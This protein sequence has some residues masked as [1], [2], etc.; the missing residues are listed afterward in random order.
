MPNLLLVGDSE[1]N[2]NLYYKT[3]FLA[4][5][6][7]VYLEKEG[8]GLLV[9]SPM[10]AGR[11]EKEAD[12][13]DVRTFDDFGYA[14]LVREL[15][16]RSAAFT[17]MLTRI[18]GNGAEPLTVEDRFPLLYGD[19]LREAR[20]NLTIDTQ[21]L[22]RERRQKTPEEVAAVEVAQQAV[23][24]ATALAID[25][26]AKSDIHNGV[27]HYN[28]IP[29]TSERLRTEIEL[30][31]TRDNMD[32]GT[33]IV[34]GGRQAADPHAIG[35][36]PIRAGE[37]VIMDIFPR[38]K[39]SRYFAD[40]TRTV[41]RGAPTDE[42]RR[43][44]EVVLQSQAAALAVIHAGANGRDVHQAVLDVFH[45][46]GYNGESGPRYTH[47]TGH[48]VGLEIHEAP[49]LGITDVELLE[50]EV[51]TVEPGLYDPEIG[52]VRIEDLVVVTRDGYRNLTKFPKTF[53][54]G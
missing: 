38:N 45:D 16:D 29:L 35:E 46:A 10:E 9:V 34:A 20:V 36:G 26:M 23:E 4:P 15:N 53:E 5:D 47:G 18:A 30:S 40:M 50:G 6:P 24:R 44:Y 43:L 48:G 28:G 41:V 39:T 8:R 54:L 27:L 21:L 51:I 25:V 31:L 17:G 14:D 49:N 12:V 2:Q 13:Q 22:R 42:L 52:G 32:P 37:A 19:K 33:P 11:A 7:F 3:R 1:T